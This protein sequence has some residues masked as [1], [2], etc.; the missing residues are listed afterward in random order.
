MTTILLI[1]FSNEGFCVCV[2][3]GK[4]NNRALFPVCR[5]LMVQSCGRPGHLRLVPDNE[6]DEDR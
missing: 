3:W 5:F 6:H 1:P 4:G 2:T